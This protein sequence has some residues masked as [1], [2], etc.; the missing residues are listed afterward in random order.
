MMYSY[1]LYT[2]GS[3][4]KPAGPG[5]WASIC[6]ENDCFSRWNGE[7]ETTNNRM[8]LMA[9]IGGLRALPNDVSVRVV[10]D[11]Q[12]VVFGF[13]T[14]LP[15]WIEHG[16]PS[17]IKNRDLWLELEK[18]VKRFY[19]VDFEHI[20]GHSGDEHNEQADRIAGKQTKL[21]RRLEQP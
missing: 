11:S 3:C 17:R 5:G 9:V 8:E 16:W 14:W 6:L 2:D 20:K 7:F 15:R 12:Y 4:P 19:C 13:T 10:S 1:T 21:F 18:Q